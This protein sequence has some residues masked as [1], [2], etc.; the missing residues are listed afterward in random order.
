MLDVRL[1]KHGSIH[2][3][4]L[5]AGIIIAAVELTFVGKN[6]SCKF[7]WKTEYYVHLEKCTFNAEA[8]KQ[9]WW[10]SACKSSRQIFPVHTLMHFLKGA[11][12]VEGHPVILV[13]FL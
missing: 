10:F 6:L 9:G 3:S 8:G 2:F 12:L 7:P 5:K 4:A 1:S 13:A 11:S